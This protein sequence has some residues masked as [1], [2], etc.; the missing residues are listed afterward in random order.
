LVTPAAG[1]NPGS[2]GGV[3]SWTDSGGHLWLFGGSI[4][5]V[6][7]TYLDDVWEYIPTT[8]EWAWMGG[9]SGVDQPGVYGTVGTPAAGNVPGGRCCMVNWTDNSGRFWLFG[10]QG[11]DANG[12]QGDLNDLW[13]LDLFTNQ[14]AW[15]GG[16]SSPPCGGLGCFAAGVYGTLGVPAAGNIPGGLQDAMS[17]TDKS[18][19]FWLFGGSGSD[20][21]GSLG[22]LNGLWE[23]ESAASAPA[24]A[25]PTITPAAGSYGT[26][27]T[28]TIGD[29]TP[30]A[31]IYYTTNGTAPNINS[32][33]Y[34]VPI[35][36]SSSETIEAI[37]TATNYSASAIATATYTLTQ[38]AIATTTTLSASATS[39]TAGQTVTLTATVT[40]ASG[41][42]PN[43]FV[44]FLNGATSLGSVASLPNGVATL[45]L[46]PVAGTYSI[47][48]S[49]DGN[50]NWETSVSSSIAITVTGATSNSPNIYTYA[51]NGTKGYTGDGGPALSAELWWPSGE[52]MDA[53]GNLYFADIVNSRIRKVD[54]ATGI[55][56]S[57]AGNGG[58]GYGGDGGPATNA[59]F[60]SLQGVSFDAAGNLYIAD[61]GNNR[62][63]KINATTGI[64]TTVAGNGTAGFSGDGGLATNAELDGPDAVVSDAAGDLFFSDL[65]NNRVRRV[66]AATGIITTVAGNGGVRFSGDGGAA[67]SATLWSPYGVGLDGAGNLYIMDN[68]NNRLRK[69]T[70]T[71]GIISTVAGNGAQGF[72]G[73][74]GPAT[75][76][77]LNAPGGDV[78]VDSAGD[79]Y[80]E[81]SGNNRVR[82]VDGTT[83]IIT[84]L[85]GDGAPSYG[86]DG[87]PANLAELQSPSGLVFDSA[88]NLYVGDTLNM[89]V[90]VVGALPVTSPVALPTF[91]PAAGSY[92]TAQTVTI[93][94]TTPGATIYYTTNGTA[95]TTNSTIYNAPITVA[96]SETLEAIATATTYSAST[97][98]TATY[99]VGQSVIATTTT[100]SSSATSLSAGQT[101]TL[102][103]TVTA[104]SGGTPAGTVT[105]YN[106]A[107]SLGSESLNGSGVAT[108]ALTSAAG[109]Y[110]IDASYGGSVPDA[111]SVSSPPVTVTVTTGPTT[112][113][114][115]Y[116][117]AGNGTAGY[118]GDGQ[119]A[120]D[121]E[122]NSPD[123]VAT[124]AGGNVYVADGKGNRVRRIDR[125]TGV[126]T[127]VA[128]TGVAAYSGDNGPAVNA[129][130]DLPFDL[131]L[132][133]A[134]N[135]Y[136]A[137]AWNA[138]VRK[139]DASSG[140]I[141][142]FA[143]K[144]GFLGVAG[145]GGPAI[146]ALLILPMG[147]A[148]DAA[149]DLYI[150]DSQWGVVR[151]VDAVT[152]IITAF[153]G[154]GGNGT[155]G[156]DGGLATA[157]HF[158]WP[159]GLAVDSA[160]NVY[161]VDSIVSVIRRV[162]AVTG[163]VTRV[164]GNG[165][166]GYSGDGGPAV[167]AELYQPNYA[168]FDATG[169]LT[170]SDSA[171]GR[172]RKIDAQTGIITTI[173]GNGSSGFSGDGG[174]AIDAQMAY[175]EGLSFDS[176][177]S[178]FIGDSFN[179]RVRVVGTPPVATQIATTTTLIAS[180]TSLTAGQ[181]LTLT[182]TVTPASG[183]TPTGAVTFNNGAVPL[184][185]ANLNGSGVATLALTP[186]V[187]SYAIIASYGGSSTDAPSASSPA[188]D[189][190]VIAIAPVLAS[191]TFTPAA[192]S[193]GTAQTVTISDTTLG[194]TI[195]YTTNGTAPNVNSSV[196]S[197]PITVASSETIEAFAAASGFSNSPAAS[198][199][200]TI[201]AKI[202]SSTSAMDIDYYTVASSDRDENRGAGGTST[203]YVLPGLGINGL[204]VFN[205]KETGS[206]FVPLDL[207][208][209][210]E[211]S[212]WSPTLNNGGPGGTSDVVQ[213]GSGS[214][215][216]PFTN[217]NFFPPNGIG[218][219]DTNGLQAAVL[220]GTLFTPA[221]ETVS[222]TISSDD[223]AFAYLDG[224]IACDDGGVHG[225]TAVPC[226]TSTISAGTHTIQ[227]FYIDL[228]ATQATLDFNLTTQN[229]CISPVTKPTIT[230]PT[231]AP[232][233]YGTPLSA[234][235]LDASSGGV[236]GTF[237]Y[238]PPAGT[239]LPAGVQTLS[240]TFTPLD[241]TDYTNATA[242][243]QLTVNKAVPT[244][245]WP[246]P[247]PITY[248]TAL[249][250]TQLDASSGGVAGAF[251]YTPAAGTVL[252]VG[253]QTL[254]AVFTPTDTTDY[255]SPTATVSI[256]V[257]QATDT[258]GLTTSA[259]SVPAG[260]PFTLTATVQ[261]STTGTPTGTVTF[262]NGASV[263]GTASL[264]NGAAAFPTALLVPGI[265]TL[266]ANYS[267]D[268]DFLSGISNP[269][270]VTVLPATTT[271]SLSASPNP[272]P[273]GT[274]VTFTATVSSLLG[275]PAG[276]VSFYDGA[277]LMGTVNLASGVA[278]YSTSGL[279]VG[280][281]N[282]TAAYLGATGFAASTSSIVVEQIADFSIS[283]SPGS[284][285]VY[286]GEAAS[287]T[288]T[289]T[290]VS[291]FNLPIALSC[292]QV[293]ANTTCSF[294]S[295]TITGN[296]GVSTLVLQT[297]APSQ[298]AGARG[299]S[300]GYRVTALAGLLLLL[301]PKRLRR[302]RKG[303]PMLLVALALLA[304]AAFTG[305]SAQRSL[306][307]GTPLGA[308]TVNIIGT[309]TNGSQTLTHETQVT[310]NVNSLF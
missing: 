23:Y 186:A 280:A 130:L 298:I 43:G 146:D 218:P 284:R 164:A 5:G 255:T 30:S 244:I 160:Q 72:G 165:G 64:I 76:A 71:T 47:T 275:T 219:N 117:Y 86:G 208:S 286:T 110:S 180:A 261:S 183:A 287:F 132:D 225:A 268:T 163:I 223:E 198:A 68:G 277:A 140:I 58:V 236:A 240:V 257:N 90:R 262:M 260:T 212:W 234:T 21:N 52:A 176:S 195:Y 88:N 33:V 50:Q 179:S 266:T 258:V 25:S 55:I 169:N 237:A 80:F 119:L 191:P 306:T 18:G 192:G 134:G 307:G 97:I 39:L 19:N 227:V 24:A 89:R 214:V 94:D 297:T 133:A 291:G 107:T 115:M 10:G 245:T 305:C 62:V 150:S 149:G 40:A 116:T 259:T 37:A 100:L 170:F 282:I 231:P 184:G 54:A 302:F 102:T 304:G 174:P 53:A 295:S 95:P 13:R 224:Q 243:V 85:A 15:M 41:G 7:L 263:L 252:P 131:A 188:V 27:Q 226:T 49:Y 70:K 124:D 309:A 178:F 155:T 267:G 238:T 301:I 182:A 233:T 292:S 129:T 256:T 83:G 57:I 84:T 217:D 197:V 269:V 154:A 59:E 158:E 151:K 105:F 293:P 206:T 14:W 28:V 121:A 1:N 22:N 56:T 137:D 106:G 299:F 189:V 148:F 285:T 65:Q 290:P 91:T 11:Y 200:Y 9:G 6:H 46:T 138:C 211:I 8:S 29:T 241:T 82:R 73:D 171:N 168:K 265:Y 38:S 36:V 215:T 194:A 35:F 239:A 109:N 161:I 78:A 300:A 51:G 66:D 126:I 111:P 45:A 175:P 92:A 125:A 283:A 251:V 159:E 93:G 145:N 20:A 187:G 294:S 181:T 193:Y 96:S 26:A 274:T 17:W 272:A 127:T 98:A 196:Y 77:T 230:W 209:D 310:L 247:A 99:T 216:L 288:V 229:V 31:V 250:A 264:A 108:L 112:S 235:Q 296:T 142:T 122:F 271:T 276:S 166:S 202:C 242:S 32:T 67:T 222:F 139:V 63:R 144:C 136:I 3:A 162:D 79:I 207:L 128:G 205:P 141:T 4:P 221:A 143:G 156:G 201:A 173:A 34:S 254:S 253:V 114:N 147:L 248:G 185:T 104:A 213:T 101:V 69:V 152:G 12:G 228:H 203:N 249:S 87:G 303:W 273:F 210:G 75:S 199:A 270:T 48:A 278:T 177:G 157:A 103:A 204:P 16:S 289:V 60:S 232:I 172:I 190:A 74:G 167:N 42:T 2:R 281:H 246:T 123:G 81:D 220:S 44:T 118:S 120:I 153:A 308:Q 61:E 279:A 113:P 135:L